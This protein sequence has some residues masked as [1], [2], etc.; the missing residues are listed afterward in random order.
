MSSAAQQ[1]EAVQ[2]LILARLQGDQ[3][4]KVNYQG[5]DGYEKLSLGELYE[6]QERLQRKVQAE[7]G[8]NF[9]LTRFNEV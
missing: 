7:Q 6:V 4:H 5:G 2:A 9:K 1:L 8:G 3:P